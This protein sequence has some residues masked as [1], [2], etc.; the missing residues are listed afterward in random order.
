MRVNA[1]RSYFPNIQTV[2]EIVTSKYEAVDSDV[3]SPFQN[4]FGILLFFL[5]TLILVSCFESSDLYCFIL[6]NITSIAYEMI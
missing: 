3:F 1:E 6:P 5:G 2:D 4:S